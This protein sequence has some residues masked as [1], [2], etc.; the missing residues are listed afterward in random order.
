MPRKKRE[1][2]EPVKAGPLNKPAPPLAS[3]TKGGGQPPA[4]ATSEEQQ[5]PAG[6]LGASPPAIP[7]ELDTIWNSEVA[8]VFANMRPKH[9][10]FLIA[11][12]QLGNA[13]KAY[14]TAY[15]PNASNHMAAVSGSKLLTTV[16]I[17][18]ILSKF[19][20]RKTEALFVAN[21]IYFDMAEAVQP[22]WVKDPASGRWVNVGENPDWGA[23]DNAGKGLTKLYALNAPEKAPEGGGGTIPAQFAFQ[24]NYY[25]ESMGVPPIPLPGLVAPAEFAD[26]FQK[27]AQGKTS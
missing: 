4:A 15:N 6:S 25:A 8:E 18:A 14:R 3:P 22:E 5:Q 26:S 23:R 2:P 16:G 20:D 7:D 10:E 24:F 12:L 19:N 9:Q 21:R 13:A 17:S 1:A 27:F 11:Y